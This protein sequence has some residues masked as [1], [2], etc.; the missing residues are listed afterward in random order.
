MTITL[1]SLSLSLMSSIM[2]SIIIYSKTCMY[3]TKFFTIILRKGQPIV[4]MSEQQSFLPWQLALHEQ[5]YTPF[6][7]R[8]SQYPGFCPLRSVQHRLIPTSAH[9]VGAVELNHT[10]CMLWQKTYKIVHLHT[11]ISFTCCAIMVSAAVSKSVACCLTS[12]WR[13]TIC[14]HACTPIAWWRAALTSVVNASTW[15]FS[16]RSTYHLLT[17]WYCSKN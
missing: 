11:S 8:T 4:L 9:V 5:I 15:S 14:S 16:S 10:T 7:S 17:G 3:T 6:P 2:C 13:S 1:I 12:T